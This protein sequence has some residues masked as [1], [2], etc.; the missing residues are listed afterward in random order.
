MTAQ[1]NKPLKESKGTNKGASMKINVIRYSTIVLLI[2]LVALAA[3]RANA[4]KRHRNEIHIESYSW[5]IAPGQIARISVV[6]FAFGDGSVRSND[7]LVVRIQLLDTEGEVIAQSDEIT[8]APGQTRFWDAPRELLPASGDSTGRLQV[9]ARI[10]V[11]TDSFD[12]G[13]SR[14]APTVELIDPSTGRSV[15]FAVQAFFHTG[16]LAVVPE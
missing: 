10:L 2:G 5:G 14:L 16:I 13:R 11:T 4:Q 6:N 7:P 9:R 3:G 8:A 1:S 12:L 15:L